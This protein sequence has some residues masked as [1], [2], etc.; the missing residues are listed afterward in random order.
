MK[1]RNR[2]VGSAPSGFLPA[3]EYREELGK[4]DEEIAFRYVR[5]I[6]GRA[7]NKI[8]PEDNLFKFRCNHSNTSQLKT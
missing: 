3:L 6:P 1:V 4:K 8:P 7:S 2:G 5:N